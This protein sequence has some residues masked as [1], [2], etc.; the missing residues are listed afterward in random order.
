MEGRPRGHPP[1]WRASKGRSQDRP[2]QGNP[3][4]SAEGGGV[5]AGSGGA[6]R[7]QHP[8]SQAQTADWIATPGA[9]EAREEGCRRHLPPQERVQG[10]RVLLGSGS[11]SC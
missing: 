1:R 8:Y 3:G 10:G 6:E 4:M 7:R 11:G 9:R 2:R 5:G